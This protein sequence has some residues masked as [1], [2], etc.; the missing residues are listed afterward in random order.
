[1]KIYL[2]LLYIL[3]VLSLSIKR[4]LLWRTLHRESADKRLQHLAIMKLK[5]DLLSGLDFTVF[6]SFLLSEDMVNMYIF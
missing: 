3:Y 5:V 2:A 4:D 1:M 6:L